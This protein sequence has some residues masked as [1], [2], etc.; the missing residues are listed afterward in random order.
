MLNVFQHPLLRGS[1]HFTKMGPETS[2]V[3]ALPAIRRK[4]PLRVTVALGP[5]AVEQSRRVDAETVHPRPDLG[6]FFLQ[7]AVAFGIAE[8]SARS[9]SDEHPDAPFDD[10]QPL[11]LE[12]LVSLGDGQRIGLLLSGQRADR[13]E[14]IAVGVTARQNRVSDRLS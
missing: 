12:A 13:G 11:V 10:D 5:F 3:T 8:A 4:A 14:G 2:V 7:E 9:R 1:R 6:P